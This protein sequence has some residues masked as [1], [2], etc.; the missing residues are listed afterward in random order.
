MACWTCSCAN[1][2]FSHIKNLWGCLVRF[3][4]K[5]W[6][7]Y[8]IRHLHGW[9]LQGLCGV[10]D[11]AEQSCTCLDESTYAPTPQKRSNSQLSLA[12]DSIWW[13][14]YA[15]RWATVCARG[16]APGSRMQDSEGTV[17]AVQFCSQYKNWH[18]CFSCSVLSLTSHLPRGYRV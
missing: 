6:R 10:H 9:L 12:Q 14:S 4:A 11:T 2:R 5:F 1:F 16:K 17:R 3:G 7:A 18:G 8:W 13:A 15:S